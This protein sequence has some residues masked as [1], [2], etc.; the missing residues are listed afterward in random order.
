MVVA[1]EILRLGLGL[2]SDILIKPRYLD[3]KGV[4]KQGGQVSGWRGG[5]GRMPAAASV[6]ECPSRI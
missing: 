1:L 4:Q 3:L 2:G 6:T 5:D